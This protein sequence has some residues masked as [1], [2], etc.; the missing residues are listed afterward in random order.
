[1]AIGLVFVIEGLLYAIAPGR[2]KDLAEMAA[3]FS[4]DTLR[5]FGLAAI[6]F[7]VLI[8]WVARSFLT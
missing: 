4:E 6:G 5:N 1:M 2:L 7:G 3:R 8:V